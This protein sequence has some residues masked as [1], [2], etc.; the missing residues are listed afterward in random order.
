MSI[1]PIN[2]V[3]LCALL[4]FIVA[5]HSSSSAQEGAATEVEQAAAA[6]ELDP[7]QAVISSDEY[8]QAVAAL[9][10]SHGAYA[11]QLPEYL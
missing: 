6:A 5:G 8:R 1:L 7:S 9:E 4:L 11:N 10:S 3:V 2:R